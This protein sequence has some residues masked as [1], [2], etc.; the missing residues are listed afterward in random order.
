[1]F[2]RKDKKVDKSRRLFF[3]KSA[4]A[5]AGVAATGAAAT[6]IGK[7]SSAASKAMNE[8][9]AAYA[10]DDRDQMNKMAQLK[11]EVMSDSDKNQMLDEIIQHHHDVA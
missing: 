2:K 3:T 5:A 8:V 10:N 9:Q 7:A 4:K 6:G 11:M 1:M